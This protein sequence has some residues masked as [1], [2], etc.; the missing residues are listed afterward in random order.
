MTRCA[1]GRAWQRP[2][3]EALAVNGF[4]C[5]LCGKNIDPDLPARHRL[6]ATV[7]HLL[8]VIDTGDQLQSIDTSRQNN[9]VETHPDAVAAER[10]SHPY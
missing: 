3:L 8:A 6:S 5:W 9:G 1:Y 2:R 7:D 10:T 4:H